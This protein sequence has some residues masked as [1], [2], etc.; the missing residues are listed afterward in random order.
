VCSDSSVLT[1][2]PVL[3]TGLA[4]A[5]V[6]ALPVAADVRLL[7]ST[8][9]VAPSYQALI[10]IGAAGSVRCRLE[11]P[12]ALRAPGVAVPPPTPEPAGEVQWS[13]RVLSRRGSFTAQV[14]CGSIAVPIEINPDV[15]Y[16]LPAQGAHSTRIS[17]TDA[18]DG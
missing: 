13:W 14:D 7:G 11:L 15:M 16:I 6:L 4:A 9:R 12:A 17:P 8:T 2:V 5:L 1:L 3:G 10:M 18:H